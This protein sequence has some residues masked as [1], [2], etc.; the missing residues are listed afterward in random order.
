MSKRICSLL[1]AVVMLFALNAGCS[2][3][4]SASAEGEF[5]EVPYQEIGLTLRY[6]AVFNNPAGIYSSWLCPFSNDGIIC[7]AFFYAAKSRA[8]FAEAA[9]FQEVMTPDEVAAFRD[10]FSVMLWVI[11]I[12]DNRS[13]TEILETFDLDDYTEKDFT[14]IGK[15]EDITFYTFES[16]ENTE[17]WLA[18]LEPKFA[19]EYMTLHDALTEVMKNAEFS[20]PVVEENNPT[21]LLLHFETTDTNGKPV[22]S[23]E[24]FAEHELTM[25][26]IWDTGCD[27]CIG[28]LE[29]LNEMNQRLAEKD[30]A[31]VGI[32]TDA[33][34]DLDKC[35]TI[36]E[37][38]HAEYL[39]LLPFSGIHE[40]L[41]TDAAPTS[42]F[43]GRNG[44]ILDYPYLG[45][46]VDLTDYETY[47][48]MILGFGKFTDPFL[49]NHK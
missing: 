11:A 27:P 32:C 34:T 12:D 1:L 5:T 4:A 35:K 43:V 24:L 38:H 17:E 8:D 49:Q 15:I 45:A 18:N 23:E 41:D 48:D 36:L 22:K 16:R 28:E 39:N 42:Y 33:D 47:I 9:S 2:F 14:E 26:N 21:G 7:E 40:C 31:V 20:V 44:R 46:P 30:C 29:G 10:L 3:N 6:P 37:E 13:A 19:E 25:V